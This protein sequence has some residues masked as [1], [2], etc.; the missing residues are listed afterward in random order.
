MGSLQCQAAPP[1]IRELNRPVAAAVVGLR[2]L[3]PAYR[4][5]LLRAAVINIIESRI[6]LNW[7]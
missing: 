3:V 4:S 1:F 7:N 5:S 6:P 2:R